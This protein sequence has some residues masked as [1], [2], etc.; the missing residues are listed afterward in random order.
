LRWRSLNR[1]IDWVNGAGRRGNNINRAKNGK[2]L[3]LKNPIPYKKAT[4]KLK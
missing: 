1:E 2:A 4:Q 3:E